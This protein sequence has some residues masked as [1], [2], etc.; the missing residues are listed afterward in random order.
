MLECAAGYLASW[1]NLR[2]VHAED[3]AEQL[4]AVAPM[5]RT[6]LRSTLW[7]MIAA[8]ILTS[9][10][11]AALF[12]MGENWPFAVAVVGF[13]LALRWWSVR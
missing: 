3:Y 1:F 10:L 6:I 5:L 9:A 13:Q 12:V 2:A 4:D 7:E 11:G 8:I